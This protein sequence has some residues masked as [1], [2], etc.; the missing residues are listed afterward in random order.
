MANELL[1]PHL[2]MAGNIFPLE[3]W[4]RINHLLGSHWILLDHFCNSVVILL[5]FFV[6]PS[7]SLIFFLASLDF[8][9]TNITTGCFPNLVFPRLFWAFFVSPSYLSSS[10][11]GTFP[12][13]PC[14]TSFLH[15]PTF[16]SASSSFSQFS[17][18]ICWLNSWRAKWPDWFQF[19]Y[20]LEIAWNKYN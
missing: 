8:S 14:L 5:I 11:D 12:P 1:R 20:R 13:Y 16:T 9:L 4:P 6:P 2:R 19:M 17:D 18:I 7:D 15:W 3:S 10:G